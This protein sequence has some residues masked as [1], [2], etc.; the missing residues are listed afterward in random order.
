MFNIVAVQIF[1]ASR[2]QKEGGHPSQLLLIS[3]TRLKVFSL[4]EAVLRTTSCH[5]QMKLVSSL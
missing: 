5:F 2:S 1:L 4:I 3:H